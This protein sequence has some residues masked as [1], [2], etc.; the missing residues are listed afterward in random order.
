MAD[1]EHRHPNAGEGDQIALY[2]FEHRQRHD[3]G[4]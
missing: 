2:L 3:G 4:T 1:L